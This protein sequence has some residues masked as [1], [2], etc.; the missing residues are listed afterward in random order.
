VPSVSGGTRWG[1]GVWISSLDLARFG[2]LWLRGGRWG[3]RQ[4][5]PADY[6]DSALRPSAH[7]PDYGFLWWLNTRQ[8]NW[9]GL[10]ANAFGARGAGNNTVFCSPDHD[11]VIVWRWHSGAAHADAQFFAKVIDA[12]AEPAGAAPVAVP[13]AA[14]QAPRGE[15]PVVLA[16]TTDGHLLEGRL[17][18][19]AV[20][21]FAVDGAQRQVPVA[22]V[23]SLQFGAPASE[24]E[25][26][27]IDKDLAALGAADLKAAEAAAEELTDIGLPVL[28]PLLRS[29]VDTDA[30]EPDLRYRLF[31]RIVPG[32][33]D[34]RDRTLDLLRLA[35]GSALRGRLSPCELRIESPL[36]APAALPSAAV[37]SLAVRRARV[38][39]TFELQA[40]HDC[41]YV[42]F[43]DSGV[44]VT[45]L[46]QVR[47]DAEGFVRLSFDEDGWATD[48]DGIKEPLPGKRKLQEGFRWGAVLGRVG[49]LG[50]RWF[51]GRHVDKN[52]LGNGR[53]YFVV[54]DNEHWQNNIGSYR[55]HL[56][57]TDAYDLGEPR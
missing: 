28:T 22:D 49:V 43:V 18:A 30:H 47:A 25:A 9:P 31:A 53:L 38:E 12:I 2:L 34:A 15:G 24:R 52:G 56:V 45:P 42:G 37:R 8:Q 39:H 27:R 36:R 33:A 41:T 44:A 26:A 40:L 20:L 5:L 6:V 46:T 16:R 13:A 50:E 23:L 57:A 3:E 19:P 29:Y 54:N 1:G 14:A 48:P 4:I 32:R 55:V 10:P 7:G 11:L 21:A 35:D 51:A 17:T